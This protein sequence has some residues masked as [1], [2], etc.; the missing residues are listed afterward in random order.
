MGAAVSLGYRL[1]SFKAI[2]V[3][4]DMEDYCSPCGNC[5]QFLR[6]FCEDHVPVFMFD[7]DG[8]YKVKTMGELLPMSFGPD[9]LPPRDLLKR[10]QDEK[11][12]KA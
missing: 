3:V 8:K 9:H 12:K 11:A 10:L 7:V 2:G 1:G 6:E 5:R 4:T